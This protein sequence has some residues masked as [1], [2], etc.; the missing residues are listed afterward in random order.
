VIKNPRSIVQR[1][2]V[3]EKGTKRRESAN[4]YFFEVAPDAN[5]IEIKE[6]VQS[7]FN[8]RVVQVRTMWMPP[9]SKRMGRYSGHT[10]AWKRA[11][12]T[13]EADQTIEL[14]EEI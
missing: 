1:A 10:A 4:Q 6:A 12:V 14:F 3:T 13:L 8:V 5:K 11:V 7:I 9:K 2:M